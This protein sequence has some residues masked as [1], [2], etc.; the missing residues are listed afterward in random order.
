MKKEV[1]IFGGAGRQGYVIADVLL[2]AGHNV[3]VWDRV[4]RTPNGAD[5]IEWDAEKDMAKPQYGAADLVVNT[6]P[7]KYGSSVIGRALGAGTDVVDLAFSMTDM[8]NFD[9]VCESQKVRLLYDCGLA[10]GIPNMIVG[11]E[12]RQHDTLTEVNILVGG[13]AA[14]PS[15]PFGYVKSWSVED[16]YE[17]YT[18][19]ARYIAGGVIRTAHPLYTKPGR[20]TLNATETLEAFYSDGLRSLLSLKDRIR[21]MRELT[22]RW[23]GHMN[24]IHF[25]IDTQGREG[26][27]KTINEKCSTGLDTVMLAVTADNVHYESIVPGTIGMTAMTRTT[28]HACAAFCILLLDNVIQRE[29]GVMAPEDV[30]QDEA[31]YQYFMQWLRENAGFSIRR[32]HG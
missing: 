27:I 21:N 14:D 20:V 12:L 13:M 1:Y 5:F 7:S 17:E 25:L 30:G 10:P 4:N 18:R 2:K 19:D 8:H 16:L 22:L 29:Y 11:N 28:A 3:V 32:V 6:L 9:D 23:Q 24:S 26:F 31:A 15:K